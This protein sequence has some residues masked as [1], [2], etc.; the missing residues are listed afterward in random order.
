[1]L[2]KSE[3]EVAYRATAYRVFLPNG[4]IELR[5][6]VASPELLQWLQVEDVHEWAILTAFNPDSVVLSDADNAVRQSELEIRLLEE[7]LEP[8]AGENV[9]ASEDGLNEQ[10]CLVPNISLSFALAIAR[11]FEQNA[12]L[13]GSHDGIPR[14]IWTNDK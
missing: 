13:H 8:Y 7:G 1:M 14:L 5:I 12:I 9:A 4:A 10:S 2:T 6:D 3:L 11:Q